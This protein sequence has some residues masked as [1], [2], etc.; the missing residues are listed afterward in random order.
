[1]RFFFFSNEGDEPPHVHVRKGDSFAELWLAPPGISYAMGFNPAELR[2]IR[3]IVGQRT[4]EFLEAW[5]E[6]RR[7]RD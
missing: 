1:M 3:Y 5:H 6:H 2:R 7:I 4:A